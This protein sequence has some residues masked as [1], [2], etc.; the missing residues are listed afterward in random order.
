M[1]LEVNRT[2]ILS[3]TDHLPG[4]TGFCR[5]RRTQFVV[6][7]CHNIPESQKHLFATVS[8]NSCFRPE[9]TGFNKLQLSATAGTDDH[10]NICVNSGHGEQGKYCT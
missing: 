8:L 2:V 5:R 4:R 9:A 1:Q 10:S 7:F 3:L 6:A